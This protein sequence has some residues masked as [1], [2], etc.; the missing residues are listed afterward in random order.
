MAKT[1][2]YYAFAM[3]V[4]FQDA[5]YLP[6]TVSAPMLRAESGSFPAFTLSAAKAKDGH[7]YVAVANADADRGYRLALDLTGAAATQV[8]GQILTAAKRDAHNTPG[9]AEEV[10]PQPYQGGKVVGAKLRLDVPA[11]AVVVV[12]LE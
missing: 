1:P 8:S 2:T 11:K 3:Y 7:I 6:V 5:T 9:E 4:P 10:A 12:K